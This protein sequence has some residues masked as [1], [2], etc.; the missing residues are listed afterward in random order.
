MAEILHEGLGKGR[1]TSNEPVPEARKPKEE[2]SAHRIQ[3]NPEDSRAMERDS[4][5]NKITG[6]SELGVP[7]SVCVLDNV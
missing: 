3:Q 2:K 1:K 5:D 4:G 6:E 7:V